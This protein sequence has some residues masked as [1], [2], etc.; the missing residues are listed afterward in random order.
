MTN[1]LPL[2]LLMQSQDGRPIDTTTLLL[3]MLLGGSGGG[4]G[5][6]SGKPGFL[7]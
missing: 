2:L 6:P 3:I 4:M 5:M 1:I 7:G